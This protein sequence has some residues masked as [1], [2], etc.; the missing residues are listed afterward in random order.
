MAHRGTPA[1]FGAGRLLLT[2]AAAIVVIAGLRAAQSILIPFLIATVLAVLAAPP[3]DW[4]KTR[5]VPTPLAVL[6]VVVVI[7]LVISA[8]GA[9][10]GASVNEFT[11]AVPRYKVRLDA[12]ETSIS[13]WI[14]ALASA[15][16]R[17]A[18]LAVR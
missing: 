16:V 3:V 18:S 2:A 5:R 17:P 10:V 11:A 6:L 4:L 13:A 15:K 1:T 8:F 14:S 9:V 7:L 12:L